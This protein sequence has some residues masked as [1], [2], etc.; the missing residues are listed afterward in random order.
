M[1]ELP[2][3]ILSCN[4]VSPVR[5]NKREKG[6]S[7]KKPNKKQKRVGKVVKRI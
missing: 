5:N 7:K 6:E 4:T 2:K 3:Y 1:K